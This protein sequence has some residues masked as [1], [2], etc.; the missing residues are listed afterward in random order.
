MDRDTATKNMKN[1]NLG[2]KMETQKLTM[3]EEFK[4]SVG[5]LYETLTDP[6]VSVQCTKSISIM[7]PFCFSAIQNIW[8]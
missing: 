5:D 2:V 1:L 7:R 4:C 3:T 6:Q 8:G